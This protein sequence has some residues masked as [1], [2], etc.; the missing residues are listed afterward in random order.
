MP[1]KGYNIKAL[2]SEIPRTRCFGIRCMLASSQCDAAAA[3]FHGQPITWCDK[4]HYGGGTPTSAWRTHAQ[5]DASL[6]NNNSTM[7]GY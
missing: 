7:I 2:T 4:L 3:G 5:I 6:C 1:Y